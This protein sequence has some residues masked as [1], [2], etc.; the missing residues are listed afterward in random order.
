MNS[1]SI[2][3]DGVRWP[4]VSS[5]SENCWAEIGKI[6]YFKAAYKETFWT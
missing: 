3:F 1:Y 2:K 6:F 4:K 5:A